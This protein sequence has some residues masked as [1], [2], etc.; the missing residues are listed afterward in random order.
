MLAV[1]H[2][3]FDGIFQACQVHSTEEVVGEAA[4]CKINAVEYGKMICKQLKKE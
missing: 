3:S 1:V 4:L 2:A